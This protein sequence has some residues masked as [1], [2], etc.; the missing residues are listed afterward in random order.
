[1]SSTFSVATVFIKTPHYIYRYINITCMSSLFFAVFCFFWY[2]GIFFSCCDFFLSLAVCVWGEGEGRLGVLCCLPPPIFL[3]TSTQTS[4]WG[5][6]RRKFEAWAQAT[7]KSRHLS[8]TIK[9]G[10]QMIFKELIWSIY[11]RRTKFSDP[12][13]LLALMLMADLYQVDGTL[14]L[15]AELLTSRSVRIL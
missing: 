11:N 7:S 13:D 14:G 5:G 2:S 4:W 12:K 9:D 6:C 8:V 15:C 1:M 10:E 3:H